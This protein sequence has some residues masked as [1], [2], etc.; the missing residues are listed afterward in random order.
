MTKIFCLSL[1]NYY[2]KRDFIMNNI[3]KLPDSFEPPETL[4]K[5]QYILKILSPKHNEIDYEA[6]TSSRDELQGIFGPSDDWP[7]Y[8]YSPEQNLADLEKHYREFNKKIAY[9]YTILSPDQAICIG[10]LYIRPTYAKDYDARVDFWFRNSHKNLE[11]QFFDELKMWL[12]NDWQFNKP[13]FPGRT[14]SWK[15]YLPLTSSPE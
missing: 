6:W 1:K 3:I 13:A 4:I 14:I 7:P 12:K 15:E 5:E 2:E 9:A 11:S 10:C 8:N